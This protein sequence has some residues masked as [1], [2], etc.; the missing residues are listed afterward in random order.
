MSV[1]N[2]LEA[3]I[4]CNNVTKFTEI[5]GQ[6]IIPSKKASVQ[7]SSSYYKI[8]LKQMECKIAKKIRPG[9]TRSKI[10]LISLLKT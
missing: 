3:P 9:P 8:I 6:N 4:P 2:L 5:V 10:F 7:V 1:I